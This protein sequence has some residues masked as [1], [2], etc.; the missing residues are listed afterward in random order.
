MPSWSTLRRLIHIS[1]RNIFRN[2]R[3]TFLTL[4]VLAFGCAGMMIIGGFFISIMDGFRDQF[5][6]SQT[7]HLQ[8]NAPDYYQYG[9]RAPLEYLMKNPDVIRRE[10][11]SAPGVAYV[12][13][14]LKLAGMASSDKASVAVL[15]TGTD[16]DLENRMGSSKAENSKI[17]SIQI[18]EGRAL[19]AAD[20]GGALLGQGLMTALNLKIGDYVTFLTTREEGAIDGGPFRIVGTFQTIDRRRHGSAAR[21]RPRY[22]D[23]TLFWPS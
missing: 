9:S 16:P 20:E 14:R 6:H 10:I 11:E 23:R 13:P 21:Y 8:V 4:G 2:R 18:V 3:R 7:G 15:V 1:W 22:A 12:V 17:P 19:T 5:V